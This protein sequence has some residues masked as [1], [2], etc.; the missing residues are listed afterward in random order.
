MA[1]AR[2]F[3]W[4]TRKSCFGWR[5]NQCQLNGICIS[6]ALGCFRIE[7]STVVKKPLAIRMLRRYLLSQSVEKPRMRIPFLRISSNIPFQRAKTSSAEK[8]LLVPYAVKTKGT[9]DGPGVDGRPLTTWML[10][11]VAFFCWTNQP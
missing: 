2:S 10:S 8:E 4:R 9:G 1:F 7:G 5:K 6:K 3:T 11:K